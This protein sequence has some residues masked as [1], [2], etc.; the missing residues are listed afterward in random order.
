M[1]TP[2]HERLSAR[3]AGHVQGV[4]FRHFTATTAGDLGLSGWVRNEPDG[5]VQLEAEGPRD[6]L[7]ELLSAVRDGPRAARV[8]EVEE[9]WTEAEGEFDGFG[10]RHAS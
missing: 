7:G 1:N 5:T 8:Q 9:E 4:G 2:T 10:V 6:Q 3:I